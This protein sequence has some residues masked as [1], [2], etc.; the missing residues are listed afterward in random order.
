MIGSSAGAWFAY[1]N[2]LNRESVVIVILELGYRFLIWFWRYISVLGVFGETNLQHQSYEVEM[3][4]EM[5]T[6]S[7]P[8][9]SSMDPPSTCDW[10]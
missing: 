9:M 2:K 7:D 6:D 3:E 10:T 8:R 4:M 5:E 1:A